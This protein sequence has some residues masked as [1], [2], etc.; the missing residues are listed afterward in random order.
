MKDIVPVTYDGILKNPAEQYLAFDKAVTRAEESFTKENTESGLALRA[1]DS[2]FATAR[3]T[4]VGFLPNLVVPD[5][6][7][8]QPTDTDKA[9]A[10]EK[11]LDTV[12]DLKEE[13]WAKTRLE[14]T[15]GQQA[16][17][18]IKELHEAIEA[19]KAFSNARVQRAEAYGPTYEKYLAFKRVVRAACGPHSK[20]YHRIH[21]RGTPVEDAVVDPNTPVPVPPPQPAK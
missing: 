3:A 15:F 14:G 4:A 8:S 6:L 12:P 10:V 20:E 21:M 5:T 18:V 17:V 9:N 1:F 11:L 7:K 19:N 16:A 13:P 2:A